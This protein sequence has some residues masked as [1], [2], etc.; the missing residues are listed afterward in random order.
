MYKLYSRS[1]LN[2][3]WIFSQIFD[4]KNNNYKKEIAFIVVSW[5]FNLKY[6][7]HRICAFV[8]L[9]VAFNGYF[10]FTL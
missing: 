7:C 10:S 5:H 6:P 9:M 1:I 4:H 2:L 3:K 8:R